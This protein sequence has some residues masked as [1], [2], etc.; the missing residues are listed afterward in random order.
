MPTEQLDAPDLLPLILSLRFFKA[1][2][3]HQ[4]T[5]ADFIYE[6]LRVGQETA[7]KQPP[8]ALEFLGQFRKAIEIQK[9]STGKQAKPA[10]DAVLWAMQTRGGD[11]ASSESD[12]SGN[13]SDAK[14]LS[15]GDKCASKALFYEV[16][17][18]LEANVAEV[19]TKRGEFFQVVE[20]FKGFSALK[21]FEAKFHGPAEMRGRLIFLLLVG[22]LHV[23]TCL[24]SCQTDQLGVER[25]EFGRYRGKELWKEIM[26]IDEEASVLYIERVTQIF[27]AKVSKDATSK[28]KK[29]AQLSLEDHQNLMD[30]VLAWKWVRPKLLASVDGEMMPKL[31]DMFAKGMENRFCKILDFVARGKT[32]L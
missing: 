23:M 18:L 8:S 22:K 21:E 3:W 26:N 13:E 19:F 9:Q 2:Y 27:D 6:S 7:E 17:R 30:S 12:A 32:K 10:Q 15:E 4:E 5:T 24:R 31:D 20:R 16:S 11:M 1:Q 25:H 29:S 14:C 28:A